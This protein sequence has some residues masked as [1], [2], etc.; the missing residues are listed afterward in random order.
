MI[1]KLPLGPAVDERCGTG[2]RHASR[3]VRA[4]WLVI[5]TSA[6]A[7]TG[8]RNQYPTAVVAAYFACTDCVAELTCSARLSFG[9]E[10]DRP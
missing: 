9:R 10:L 5:R 6:S 8:W 7:A 1:G 4:E 3:L 2:G